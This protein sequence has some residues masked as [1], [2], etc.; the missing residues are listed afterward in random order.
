MLLIFK[1]FMV[2]RNLKMK[3]AIESFREA[4]ATCMSICMSKIM[5]HMYGHPLYP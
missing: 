2:G 5:G 4:L 1:S 3:R